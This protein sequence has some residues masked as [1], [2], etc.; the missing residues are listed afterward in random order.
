MDD[1]YLGFSYRGIRL[2]MDKDA[3]FKGFIENSGEDLIFN[4][5]PE[6][7]NE[8]ATVPF[9]DQTF[10]LGN[11]KT[12]RTFDF[13]VN[14]VEINLNDYR[15]FLNWLN[16]D[17]KGTLFFDYNEN[18]GFDVKVNSIGSGQYVVVTKCDNNSDL[19]NVGIDLS[20]IT[21][22]D[23]AARW[24]KEGVYWTG[25]EDDDDLIDNEFE[26]GKP[27][28]NVHNDDITFTNKHNLPNYFILETNGEVIIQEIG[29][30]DLAQPIIIPPNTKFFSQYGIGI[31]LETNN[32]FSEI[33]NS[34]IIEIP[35]MGDLKIVLNGAST[36][37]ITRITPISREII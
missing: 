1:K 29:D 37:N 36:S 33:E 11:S 5:S 2:G 20:F 30:D 15:K 17:S 3:N 25:N 6:F 16:L 9:G 12:N 19:Y 4:N 32:T 22:G 7:S 21:T 31:D 35:P 23:W 10:Y 24:V 28:L 34:R 8:F 27:F 13:R 14:L 26:G 18:Y